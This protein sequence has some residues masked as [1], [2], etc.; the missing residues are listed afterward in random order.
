MV[1]DFNTGFIDDEY[2]F[3][4]KEELYPHKDV[5]L[6]SAAI[7]ALHREQ[8]RALRLL[9]KGAAENSQWRERGKRASLRVVSNLPG[10]GWKR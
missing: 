8:E 10:R 1:G 3:M 2:R 5:A 7:A 9:E 4:Q 6:A